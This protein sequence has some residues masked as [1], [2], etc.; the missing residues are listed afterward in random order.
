[1]TQY[2]CDVLIVGAG[3]SGAMIAYKA[4][5]AGLKVIVLEA[6]VPFELR[7]PWI[8]GYYQ[9]GWP[10][11]SEAA[12]PQQNDPGI[13][14]K[15]PKAN[16]WEQVGPVGFD[17]TYERRGGGTTLH[18]LG[19]CMRFVP[20]D[21]KVQSV[22][23]APGAMDWPV[24]YD[25]LEPWYCAAETEIG[26]SGYNTAQYPFEG[27]RSKPYPMSPL[28]QSYLDQTF[29]A[30]LDGKPVNAFG[31]QTPL[32]VGI[33][34]QGRNTAAYDSRPPCMG[35]S[36]CVPICPIQAKYDAT[37]HI[38]KAQT[39]KVPAQIRFRS[40]VTSLVIDNATA[41]I[42]GVNYLTWGGSGSGEHGTGGGTL[43]ART[44]VVAAHAMETVKILLNSPW[45]TAS[46]VFTA[47]NSSDQVGRNL[48][49]HICQLT[50]ALA[51]KPVYPFRGPLSTSGIEN[52]RDG[53][54]R[55]KQAAYRIEIGNDGWSWP[56]GAP[57]T[58]AQTLIAQGLTGTALRAAVA[59]RSTRQIRMAFEME[60]LSLASSRVTLSNLKD[61]LGQPR[62]RV[63]YNLAPY[64]L[65]SFVQ[66][67]DV[68]NQM[69]NL[70]GVKPGENFTV[71][72]PG[73]PGYFEYGGKP[74]QFR[75]AGHVIGT[76]RMGSDPKTSVVDGNLRSHDHANLYL[77]GSGTFPTTGTANP[78][79][80]IAAMSLRTAQTIVSSLTGAAKAAA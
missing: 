74:Y 69:L 48:S 62:P 61:Q 72:N 7:Q 8:D 66:S 36:S 28:P 76:Y 16:Y 25:D 75:G 9:N 53:P 6:G 41:Q 54:F 17:S 55:S 65:D 46:G 2:D 15:N 58:D 32:T 37:V 34:P 14:W 10:F 22:Y 38:K 18:W 77:T 42:A 64:T 47:A 56:T 80:T 78:T 73:S 23:H 45:H 70:I 43:T 27:K 60:S 59:D 51:P 3:I 39:A 68:A 13:D 63:A 11:D 57:Q 12:A 26:V 52:F 4:A 49:D 33:T 44:Y 35:N 50:W 40:V 21:F 67:V 71:A 31:T 1:M 24:S 20:N 30:A 29:M 79:L 5:S 19:T